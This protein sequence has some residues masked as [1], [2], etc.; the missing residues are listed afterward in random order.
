MEMQH[1]N[2]S[3]SGTTN[4]KQYKKLLLMILLS[5]VAMYVLMYSMVNT[6]SNVTNNVNQFYMAGLMTMPMVIIELTVMGS[7]YME[8]KLNAIILLSGMVAMI[9]F[10]F[11]IREQVGV[12]DKQFLKSMIPH[13][14]AAILMVEKASLTDPEIKNLGKGIIAAQQAEIEQMKAKLK[15]LDN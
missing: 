2:K 8:K 3:K 13:H 1:S 12:S 4:L 6:F 5:F 14:A 10:F 7:M 9:G 15:A 11:C